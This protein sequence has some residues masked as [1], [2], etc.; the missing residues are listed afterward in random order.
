MVSLLSVKNKSAEQTRRDAQLGVRAA[1]SA[2]LTK[3]I[4]RRGNT[5]NEK[6]KAIPCRLD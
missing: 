2:A 5:D 1:R 6:Q 4:S 3:M